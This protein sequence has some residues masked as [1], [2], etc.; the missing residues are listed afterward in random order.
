MASLSIEKFITKYKN[1]PDL[2]PGVKRRR[3]S[4]VKMLRFFVNVGMM[5]VQNKGQF[6]NFICKYGRISGN[7]I[8]KIDLRK[9]H[10]YF[11][12]EA[13]IANK[14]TQNF[15]NLSIAGRDVRLNR[16]EQKPKAKSAY[17]GNF[18]KKG[19]KKKKKKRQR[20]D[21]YKG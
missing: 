6:L 14:L 11:D 5:D 17:K 9:T 1:A 21:S 13:D 8:G 19:H 20:G 10:S 7:S 15:R 12:V 16:D 2:N 3:S 18:K 4:S